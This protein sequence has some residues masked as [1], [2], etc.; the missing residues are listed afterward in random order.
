M[1]VVTLKRLTLEH[2]LAWPHWRDLASKLA[3]P[4]KIGIASNLASMQIFGLN[5][6][7]FFLTYLINLLILIDLC[8]TLIKIH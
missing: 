2:C 8:S 6:I 1:I 7:F 4:K 5:F 3:W